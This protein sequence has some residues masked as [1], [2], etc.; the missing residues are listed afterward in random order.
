MALG[1]LPVRSRF[2]LLLFLLLAGK[3]FEI[4]RQWFGLASLP[5]AQLLESGA[6]G[7]R[8]WLEGGGFGGAFPPAHI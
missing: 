5:P 6:L 8:L 7:G 4:G 3:L 1:L 2:F